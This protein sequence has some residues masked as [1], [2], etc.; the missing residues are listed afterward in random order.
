MN[1]QTAMIPGFSPDGKPVLSVLA[2]KT[3]TICPGQIIPAQMQPP[4]N[5]SDIYADPA[6]PLGSEIL[7]ESDLIPW[8]QNTDI[9]VLSRA[10]SP[11]G[12]K[13]FYLD[14][15][16]QIGPVQKKIRVFGERKIKSGLVR[17]LRF[18]DPIPYQQKGLGW[19]NAY[20]GVAKSKD[21]TLLPY[22]PNPIGRGFYIKRGFENYSEIQVP[23][24]EDPEI[25]LQP[26]D[27]ILR[28][29]D[30][31]K[32]APKPVCFGWAKPGFF[33]RFSF[34]VNPTPDFRFFQGASE[35]LC[36]HILGGDEHVK[37]TYMDPQKP[38]FE[39]DLPNE[40]PVVTIL[41]NNSP[42][43]LT[44]VLQTLLINKENNCLF[45][46]WRASFQYNL[47]ES[48]ENGLPQFQVI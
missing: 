23:N 31:W 10:Y 36:N 22:P 18:T 48:T 42:V 16:V 41:I 47:R 24:L 38:V 14:C 28:K 13:A 25:P 9:I 30:D 12:K 35:G 27:L 33:P 32:K 8:K 44:S 34:A 7:E 17:G 21:G 46:V 15:E 11:K 37:L 1:W 4:L 43:E 5:T 3:Y 45:M 6:N 39:F 29:F 2:K 20:G 26:H 19:T 40:K